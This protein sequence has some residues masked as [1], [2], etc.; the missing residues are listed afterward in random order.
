MKCCV[1]QY[2]GLLLFQT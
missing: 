1:I 2:I